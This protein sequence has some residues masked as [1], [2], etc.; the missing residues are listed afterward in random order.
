[1]RPSPIE[2][3]PALLGMVRGGEGPPA[4]TPTPP[5]RPTFAPEAPIR[6]RV[7]GRWQVNTLLG[8]MSGEGEAA[9]SRTPIGACL[10]EDTIENCVKLKEQKP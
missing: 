1:M 3:E 2:I 8:S 7:E 5:A 6:R 9:V 10:E 4:P